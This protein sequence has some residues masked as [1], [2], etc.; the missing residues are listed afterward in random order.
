MK[1]S[2]SDEPYYCLSDFVAPKETGLC[3]YIGLFAVSAGFGCDELCEIFAKEND[4]YNVIM[5]KAIADRFAEAFAE[6]LHEE[7]RRE[8]WGYAPDEELSVEAMLQV[9][10]QGIRPA[11]GY[12]SQPV[13]LN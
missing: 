1:D 7:V 3:D 12:P 11:P 2:E 6:R 4:D 9:K 5:T 8:Y 10:Y 13:R